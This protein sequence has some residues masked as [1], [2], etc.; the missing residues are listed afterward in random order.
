ML[1]L[2]Y[3]PAT[4]LAAAR[5]AIALMKTLA[6]PLK[7]AVAIAVAISCDDQLPRITQLSVGPPDSAH[8]W[9]SQADIFLTRSVS[10]AEN[11]CSKC[12][13]FSGVAAAG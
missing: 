5:P 6:I 2:R 8:E 12:S 9:P 13:P 11:V 7:I 4:G 10:P 1:R 3:V